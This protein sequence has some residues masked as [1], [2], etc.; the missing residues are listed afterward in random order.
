MAWLIDILGGS[1]RTRIP[2]RFYITDMILI[3]RPK[4][5]LLNYLYLLVPRPNLLLVVLGNYYP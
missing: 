4:R 5:S 1:A 2:R 3:R